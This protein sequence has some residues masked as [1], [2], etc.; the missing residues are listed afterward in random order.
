[1]PECPHDDMPSTGMIVF[2]HECILC[3]TFVLMF[4]SFYYMYHNKWHVWYVL[5]EKYIAMSIC[6]AKCKGSARVSSWHTGPVFMFTPQL[7]PPAYYTALLQ[8]QWTAWQ[9]VNMNSSLTSYL[10]HHHVT[11][12][13]CLS[14]RQQ[15]IMDTVGCLCSI[16]VCLCFH[17]F[18]NINICVCCIWNKSISYVNSHFRITV[19]KSDVAAVYILSYYRTLCL[20]I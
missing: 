16:A 19:T 4:M 3:T 1:M 15:S 7:S 17:L 20:M 13:V 6:R 9:H 14:D 18:H 8:R 12:F 10:L 5:K 2:H 11:S